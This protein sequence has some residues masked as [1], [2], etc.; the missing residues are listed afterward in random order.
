MTINERIKQIRQTLNLTQGKFAERIAISIGYLSGI[1]L[2]DKT[3]NDR[4]ILLVSWEFGVNEHWLRTGEG[5]MYDESADVNIANLNS[6]FK[7]LAPTYQE[8][9]LNQLNAL[10]DLQSNNRK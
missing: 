1:E 10:V 3:V 7:S 8:C 4:I 5:A 6:L 9:A 2:G